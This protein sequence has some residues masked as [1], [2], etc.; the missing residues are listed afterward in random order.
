M[1]LLLLVAAAVVHH[2][3]MH[4]TVAA[5]VALADLSLDHNSL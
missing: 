4:I 5:E 2:T 1:F 3:I